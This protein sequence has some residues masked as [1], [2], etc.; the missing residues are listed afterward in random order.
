VPSYPIA[1]AVAGRIHQHFAR[2]LTAELERGGTELA[3]LPD[4]AAIE[5]MIDAAF[6]A[7]LRQNERYPLKVTMAWLA[8]GDTRLPMNFSQRLPLDVEAVTR[9]APAVERPGVHLGVWRDESGFHIWGATRRLPALCFVL[10]VLA[11]GFLV[12]KHRRSQESG[13]YVNVAV[14]EGD[15]IKILNPQPVNL[16]HSP[17]FV[18]SLFGVE[19]PAPLG[20]STN[21]MIQLAV[22]MREHGRG[23]SLLVVPH[24]SDTWRE[25]MATP[26]PYAVL[27]AYTELADLIRQESEQRQQPRWQEGL[28]R[29]I[30]VVAGLTAVDGAMVMTDRCELLGF[31][32][33]IGRRDGWARVEQVIDSEP[34]EG[35]TPH[36]VHP[37]HLGGTRHLSGAQFGQDQRDSVAMVA[38]QDGRFTV[39]A[40]SAPSQVVQ[41]YRVETLLL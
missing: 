12:V 39:F 30:D 18:S 8:P 28:R 35:T 22:S 10:E 17:C 19:S 2:N 13:K 9:L 3:P 34:V 26:V 20:S 36:L 16:Q 11:P 29:S 7:S 33:K 38:S 6:W 23:G 5:T 27:P 37:S 1:R 31:G 41:A 40:W 14:L 24:G 21:V 4:E 15:R 32:A 25:S